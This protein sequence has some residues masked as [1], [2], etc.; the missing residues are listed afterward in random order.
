M[1]RAI[2]TILLAG[3]VLG[4][5]L[6]VAHAKTTIRV[7]IAQYSD[8]TGPWFDQVRAAFEKANPDIAVSYDVVPWNTLQQKLT[9]EISGGENPDLS[10]IGTRWLLDFQK[11]DIVAPLEQYMD[12]AF[13][14]RFIP[15]FLGPSELGGKLYGLPV[16]ASAR[17]MYYNKDI[18]SKA[19]I[20]TPPATWDEVLADCKAIKAANPSGPYCFGL[21]GKEIETDVYFYYALWS[22][23][24]NIIGPDGKSGIDSAAALKA[25]TLYRTMIEDGYTEPGPTAYNR[26]DVQ[27]QFKQ[28]RVAMMI[29]A[30]FLASQIHTEAPKLPYGIVP[31]PKGTTQITYGVTDSIVL[32][33][34]SQ[35]KA[36]AAKFLEFMFEPKWR[37]LFNQNEGFLPVEKSVAAM[38]E[39][40]DSPDL[41]VFDEVLPEAKF[42]PLITGWEQAADAT[43]SALQKIY[44][45]QASPADALKQAATGV[46][47]AIS[48]G[49]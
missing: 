44:L 13:R 16:A 15:T 43:I 14:A 46:N 17:A 1:R 32:F 38:P 24:G 10:I 20:A 2:R 22:Y 33:A 30:P 4:L 49:Q 18:L 31:I 12:A 6:G 29:T 27:N 9:T 26:E 5:G 19:G 45:G 48:G 23:G 47:A 28:G 21:Q 36:E 34:N 25:A 39:F 8:K 35:H 42:A 3:S 11:Q 41:K 7:T 37:V 40:A